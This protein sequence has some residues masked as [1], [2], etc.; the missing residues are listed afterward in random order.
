MVKT[1]S[2]MKSLCHRPHCSL[3]FHLVVQ[4]RVSFA[5]QQ[6]QHI[7]FRG[8]ASRC[9]RQNGRLVQVTVPFSPRSIRKSLHPHSRLLMYTPLDDALVPL[10][11]RT[12]AA[13]TDTKLRYHTFSYAIRVG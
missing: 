12:F 6:L 8:T 7:P 11:R 4:K 2:V 5:Q 9:R 3:H 1:I 13:V 10:H